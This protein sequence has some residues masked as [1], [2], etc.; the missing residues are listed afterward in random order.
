MNGK[1]SS[2]PAQLIK[3]NADRRIA[4]IHYVAIQFYPL[5][6]ADIRADRH[7]LHQFSGHQLAL[8]QVTRFQSVID[9]NGQ[10]RARR[11]RRQILG[12]VG[13]DGHGN[14]KDEKRN[15]VPHHFSPLHCLRRPDANRGHLSNNLLLPGRKTQ[16]SPLELVD[17]TRSHSLQR[18]VSNPASFPKCKTPVN[19]LSTGV[20]IQ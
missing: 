2:V 12:G 17:R 3:E 6:Q 15:Q 7:G 5:W 14:A 8:L 4:D 20:T 13:I 19:N 10:S 11:W 1:S 16:D 18:G 9:D